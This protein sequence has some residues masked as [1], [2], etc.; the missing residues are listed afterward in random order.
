MKLQCLL[1]FSTVITT[2]AFAAQTNIIFGQPNTGEDDPYV[3]GKLENYNIAIGLNTTFVGSGNLNFGIESKSKDE[4]ISIG[5]HATSDHESL[6]LGSGSVA[7]NKSIAIGF[8]SF[9]ED[10]QVSIGNIYEQRRI[11]NMAAGQKATD[12]VNVSQLI[13]LKNNITVNKN[14]IKTVEMI[15]VENSSGISNNKSQIETSKNAITNNSS[16]ISINKSTIAANSTSISNN[17]GQIG[18]NKSVISNN[19]SGIY[20]NKSAIA[21]NSTNISNNK[22]QIET[23]KSVITNNSSDIVKN[24]KLAVNNQ[25]HISKNKTHIDANRTNIQRNS[26]RIEYNRIDVDNKLNQL[27]K[28]IYQV[29][30][31]ANAGTASAMAMTQ[32]AAPLNGYKYNIGIGLGSYGEQAATALGAKFRVNQNTTVGLT[33]SYDSQHNFGT[34]VGANWSF[35]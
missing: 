30:K 18:T 8:H 33:S 7:S 6:A 5:N 10:G 21:A 25:T 32:I 22:G 29:R 31:R 14:K 24:K 3:N 4:S 1:L 27:K 26:A 20:I 17:K 28:D 2:S 19:S 34:S 23:N 35:N 16:G 11:E 15:V 9:S 13:P 12:G